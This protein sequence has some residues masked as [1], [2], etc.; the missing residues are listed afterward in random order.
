MPRV[1][2]LP[3][4]AVHHR[5]PGQPA[6]LPALASARCRERRVHSAAVWRA[7]ARGE[8]RGRQPAE[9]GPRAQGRARPP[10]PATRAAA[11]PARPCDQYRPRRDA[12]LS[13]LTVLTLWQIT[14]RPISRRCEI[15]FVH[16]SAFPYLV[17]MALKTDSTVDRAW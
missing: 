10:P 5:K 16:R 7:R 11:A 14:L 8:G 9:R 13:L 4:K 15:L 17:L 12:T 6:R 3:G 1:G 2:A